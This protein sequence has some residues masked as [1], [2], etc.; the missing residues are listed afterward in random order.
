MMQKLHSTTVIVADQEEALRFY[1]DTLGWEKRQDNTMGEMRWLTVAPRGAETAVVL[2]QPE[3]YNEQAP[4]PGRSKGCGIS[5]TTDDIDA[6]YAALTEKG[7][8]F[9]Q[10]PEMMPWG[11]KATWFTDPSGNE[12]FLVQEMGAAS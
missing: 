5:V 9:K 4:G 2:G 3:V 10:A 7:V 6:E 8:N 12:F 1:V 11:D